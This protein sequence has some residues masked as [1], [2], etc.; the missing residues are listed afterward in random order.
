M[1]LHLPKTDLRRSVQNNNN[2]AAPI[3]Q[4][5]TIAV[6]AQNTVGRKRRMED[7]STTDDVKKQKALDT[8]NV[9]KLQTTKMS[10]STETLR[11]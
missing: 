1:M 10:E 9:A 3:T 5:Y 11:W 6:L 7:A 2:N 8:T 4:N